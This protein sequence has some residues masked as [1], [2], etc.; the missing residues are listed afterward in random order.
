MASASQLRA[1]LDAIAPDERV[2]LD[3]VE[4]TFLDC[5]GLRVLETAHAARQHKGGRLV[6]R[7]SV[8]GIPYTVIEMGELLAWLNV[9]NAT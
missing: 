6:V 9:E 5:A 4:V 8:H 3:L 7:A 1:A 2:V